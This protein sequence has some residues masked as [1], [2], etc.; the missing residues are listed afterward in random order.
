MRAFSVAFLATVFALPAAAQEFTE[1]AADVEF[2]AAQELYRGTDVSFR[3]PADTA[4][5]FRLTANVS[6]DIEAEMQAESHVLWPESMTQS[7]MGVPGGGEVA[8][9]LDLVASAEVGLFAPIEIAG[10]TYDPTNNGAN[11]SGLSYAL[12]T[13]S[14]QWTK[15]TL[16][17]SLLLP[18]A[19]QQSVG[20]AITF[21]NGGESW[22]RFN[23]K[24][25]LKYS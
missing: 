9:I 25:I 1:S 21:Q 20:V 19:P 24:M 11:P 18:G 2:V 17:D 23:I 15:F 8:V 7:W 4:L 3:I 14:W 5:G 10:F 16:F 13:E 22:P 6:A 12:W